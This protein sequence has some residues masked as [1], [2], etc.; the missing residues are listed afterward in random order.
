[1]DSVNNVTFSL[2]FVAG[3]LSFISPCVLPLIPAYVSYLGG[4]ATM[5]VMAAGAAGTGGPG[6]A[7]PINRLEGF[8]N[9]LLF[10]GGFTFV[11]LTF[12]LLTHTGPQMLPAAPYDIQL[13]ITHIGGLL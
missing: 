8:I 9:G 6:T 12:G 2:A 11:F 1:M 4:R 10:V 5:Q 7:L 13:L 3:F